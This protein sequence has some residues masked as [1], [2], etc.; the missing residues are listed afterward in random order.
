MDDDEETEALVTVAARPSERTAGDAARQLLE[1]GVAATVAPILAP[2]EGD[3]ADA[4][5]GKTTMVTNGFA[6]QVLPHDVERACEL[7]GVE[8]P[9]EVLAEQAEEKEPAPPWKRIL[10][11]WA[12]A[13]VTIPVAAGFAAYFL[14][15]R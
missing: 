5:G 3:T 2:S 15:S 7:L 9:A 8:V 11:I 6:V 14:L 12:I 10:V 13:M 4:A 1:R